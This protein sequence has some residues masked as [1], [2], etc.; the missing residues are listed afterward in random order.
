MSKALVMRNT[1]H[2][3][4]DG[5]DLSLCG[6]PSADMM[7][8][9]ENRKITGV[10]HEEFG[11][12]QCLMLLHE[13]WEQLIKD[14]D[15]LAGDLSQYSAQDYED[16]LKCLELVSNS[17]TLKGLVNDES[18]VAPPAKKT[19]GRRPVKKAGGKA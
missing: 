6:L 19:T 4:V 7:K 17:P 14:Y 1:T 12:K 5:G 16:L 11:C 10:K 9:G 18:E 13:K 3:V 15:Q 2:V 8:E